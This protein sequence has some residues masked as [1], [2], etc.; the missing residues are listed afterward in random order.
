MTTMRRLRTRARP[1]KARR[2]GTRRCGNSRENDGCWRTI[3]RGRHTA[4]DHDVESVFCAKSER[5][6][7]CRRWMPEPKIFTGPETGLYVQ[8]AQENLLDKFGG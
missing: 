3:L 1:P 5:R 8:I 6:F 7:T 2:V 4:N